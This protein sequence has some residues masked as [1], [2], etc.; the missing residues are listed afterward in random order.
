M[1]SDYE[2][3]CNEK[4]L[5]I[6]DTRQRQANVAIQS[7]MIPQGNGMQNQLQGGFPQQMNRGLQSSPVPGQPQMAMGMNDPN[8]QAAMQQRQQQQSAMLQQ[9]APQRPANGGAL[10]DDLST[11]APNEFEHVKRL[12]NQML[13][14]TSPEDMEKIKM[15]LSNMTPEQRQYLVRKDMDPMTYFFRSQALSQLRRHRRNRMD[16]GRNA[17]LAMD[18]NGGMMSDPN[19]NQQQQRQ[20]LQ[21]M[22]NL[23]RNSTIAGNANQGIDPNAFM[24][25]VENIQGQQADGMRSQ[26]AGQLVVPASSSQMNHQPFPNQQT[27][28]SPQVNQNGQQLNGAGVNSNMF[29]QQHLQ[30][31]SNGPQDRLHFQNQAQAQAAAAAARAQAAQKAQMAMSGHGQHNNQNQGHMPQSSPVMPMLNQ[32][33]ANGQISP[34]QLPG[35]NRPQ[36]RPPNMG[37]LPN[38]AQNGSQSNIPR[39]QIP[40]NLPPAVHSHLAQ[41]SNEQLHAFLIAQRRNQM[42]GAMN[43]GRPPQ[44]GGQGQAM[45]NNQLANGAGGVRNPMNLPQGMNSAG[46]GQPQQMQGQQMTQQ[47]RAAQQQRQEHLYKLHLMRQQTL[48]P[49]NGMEMT[50]E[51]IA[52]MDR[53]TFPMNI[54][55]NSTSQVPKNIK[56]WGQLKQFVSQHP[57]AANGVDISKLMTLQ[58]LQ[59]AQMMA[60]PPNQGTN[61]QGPGNPSQSMGG[62]PQMMGRPGLQNNGQPQGPGRGVP[63]M[64]PITEHDIQ[65]AR[66]KLGP[67]SRNVTDDQIRELL[68]SRQ[69]QIML[70]SRQMEQAQ[71]ANGQNQAMPQSA[72]PSMPPT[73]QMPSA[74]NPA[75]QQRPSVDQGVAN[76]RAQAAAAVAATKAKATA[77]KPGPKKKQNTD[78]ASNVPA[79]NTQLSQQQPGAAPSRQPN[80]ALLSQDQFQAMNPQQRLQAEAHMRKQQQNFI[81]GPILSKAAAEKAWRTNVPDRILEVY[82]EIDRT[83]PHSQPLQIPL[84]QKQVMSQLM[85]DSLDVVCRLDMVVTTGFSRMQGQEKTLRNLLAMRC[86]IIRQ[87]SDSPDW[88]LNDN[89]T[90]SQEYLTGGILFI[91]KLFQLMMVKMNQ[92]S[93]RPNPAQNANGAIASQI[94][95]NTPKLNATNLQ[96]LQEQQE[97]ALQRARRASSQSAGQNLPSAA[98]FGA[99]SPQGVPHAYGPNGLQP[100]NLKLP[101]PKRRKPS[102]A[103]P[104]NASPIQSGASPSTAN[105]SKQAA[106][107]PDLFKCSVVDCQHHYHGFPTQDALTKHVE[108]DH[109]PEEEE[110]IGDVLQ[111]YSQSVAIGLGLNPDGQQNK[112]LNDTSAAAVANIGKPAMAS[113]AKNGILTPVTASNTPMARANSQLGNKPSTPQLLTPQQANKPKP[114]P[115]KDAKQPGK[116]TLDDMEGKDPWAECPISLETLHDSFSPVLGIGADP[117]DEFLNNDMFTLD[118][119]DN[120]P[121]SLD[122]RLATMT[123]TLDTLEHLDPGSPLPYP[124]WEWEPEGGFP[125]P[126]ISDAEGQT[127]GPNPNLPNGVDAIRFEMREG[128]KY[129]NMVKDLP[130]PPTDPET[131]MK[132][133]DWENIPEPETTTLENGGIAIA[134]V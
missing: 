125:L 95:N 88:T 3:E 80:N 103:G 53:L 59:F 50:P 52:D 71:L 97:E 90:I 40:P 116:R 93:Q 22:F 89:F 1:Q 114:S 106:R 85:M 77:A 86:S 87:F 45:F 65:M 8:Q 36:P 111:Y 5:H 94:P 18:P 23:Q 98:P 48:G 120:T 16:M 126:E 107:N 21:N 108:E 83:A 74:V 69:R 7:G 33:M 110:E 46:P 2:R 34:A 81:K 43:G 17:N 127:A 4:L 11:L 38:G 51:Q 117:C 105:K 113:P 101:P 54:L 133:V 96:Q 128:G 13:A 104:V 26:E 58:K 14:K 60:A 35:Q 49:N 78:D 84:E 57:Q 130:E 15:N 134:T 132:M 37:Q 131:L 55:N 66:T 76:A 72:N 61:G 10:P 44:A 92:Q 75:Q 42:A 56:T 9:R 102:Q 32:P 31:G 6:K 41:M 91:R 79:Q 39:P 19:I 118:Q 29:N 121:D 62:A 64:R 12:A 119:S 28:F 73:V 109:Q 20:L 70:K 129:H 115:T 63:P 27:M 112:N 25:S 124:W 68:Q 123:P 67:N 82:D 100:G 99:P 122:N 47:Q 24:G 30:T